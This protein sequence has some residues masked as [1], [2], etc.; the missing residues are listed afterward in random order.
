[1]KRPK[2]MERRDR[3]HVLEK[4]L[5]AQAQTSNH[6]NVFTSRQRHQ[7]TAHQQQQHKG[8]R[9]VLM[10]PCLAMRTHWWVPGTHRTPVLVRG[11]AVGGLHNKT[12]P[13][14][15]AQ[16]NTIM[17][18]VCELWSP[19]QV[20]STN[21]V[22]TILD[23]TKMEQKRF[24]VHFAPATSAA[25][26]PRPPSAYA[27]PKSDEPT[28]PSS[29]SSERPVQNL[30]CQCFHDLLALGDGPLLVMKALLS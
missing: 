18:L 6:Q 21:A 1:M 11:E 26:S 2:K 14:H 16:S 30:F 15:G 13:P 25:P 22:H 3:Q 19:A 12:H 9:V 29:C 24:A 28:T 20:A 23:H 5:E 17:E 10:T 7:T 4:L 8:W 27:R